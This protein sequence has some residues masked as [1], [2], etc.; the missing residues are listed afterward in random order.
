MVS[1]ERALTWCKINVVGISYLD[2][3]ETDDVFVP[4]PLASEVRFGS[5]NHLNVSPEKYSAGT[6][7]NV[8]C[9][10]DNHCTG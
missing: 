8:W 10:V 9:D 1:E 6:V 5:G 2:L 4:Q 7:A 3:R